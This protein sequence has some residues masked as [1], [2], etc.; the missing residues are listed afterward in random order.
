MA[1][2]YCDGDTELA[3][4]YAKDAAE[5]LVATYPNHSWWC[6]CR[7]GALI[8]K[9][10]TISERIGMVKHVSSLDHD[11]GRRKKDIVNAAGEFLERAGLPRAGYQGQAVKDFE[12]DDKRMK[13][14]WRGRPGFP[15]K[16]IH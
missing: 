11:A 8:I 7:G 12:T 9:L 16:V 1:L 3:K 4:A 15:T 2:I 10:P 14:Y 5:I 13:G 6:E